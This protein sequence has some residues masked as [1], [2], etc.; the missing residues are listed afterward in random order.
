MEENTD[1]GLIAHREMW[2]RLCESIDKKSKFIKVYLDIEDI[3]YL[4][5]VIRDEIDMIFIEE[6]ADRAE[7][8]IEKFED[9]LE[10]EYE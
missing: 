4:L 6:E 2:G 8:L 10:H 3:K 9:I 7:R 1:E 5:G